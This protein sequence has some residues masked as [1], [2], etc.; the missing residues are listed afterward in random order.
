VILCPPLRKLAD[1]HARWLAELGRGRRGDEAGRAARLLALW[2][3]EIQPHCRAED[4]V[5]LPELSRRLS[6]A[7]AS[8][9]FT[10]GDHLALRQLARE[11]RA[12]PGPAREAA[13]ERLERKLAEHLDFEERT[14]LPALQVT[15]GCTRLAELAPELARAGK[16]SKHRPVGDPPAVT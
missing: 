3:V 9:V 8:I 1:E 5:L 4:E 16:P 14:L 7:E 12:A 2:D 10:L 6:E 15:L 13:A 11:L